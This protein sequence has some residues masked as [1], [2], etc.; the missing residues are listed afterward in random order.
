MN[1]A[2][3][4]DSLSIGAPY[5]KCLDD[6]G[7]L[8]PL[9]RGESAADTRYSKS[10]VQILLRRLRGHAPSVGRRYPGFASIPE[11]HRIF[12][13]DP[14]FVI[15]T[16]SQGLISASANLRDERGLRAV[17]VSVRDVRTLWQDTVG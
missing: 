6:T 9:V 12:Q 13:I 10:D 1:S 4:R 14:N 3:T 7:I 8:R 5:L 17:L 2:Q 15:S 11:F 16:V